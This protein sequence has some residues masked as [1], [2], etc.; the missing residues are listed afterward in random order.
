MTQERVPIALFPGVVARVQVST[1]LLQPGSALALAVDEAVGRE[2]S[3]VESRCDCR[4]DVFCWGTR[5]WWFDR[6]SGSGCAATTAGARLQGGRSQGG[7]AR[8][9]QWRSPR[10][11]SFAGC[12]SWSCPSTHRRWRCE[13]AVAAALK[14]HTVCVTRRNE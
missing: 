3:W 6:R 14:A 4:C 5:T 11:R 7:R 12:P 9:L 10:S 1:R 2:D 8:A 13:S